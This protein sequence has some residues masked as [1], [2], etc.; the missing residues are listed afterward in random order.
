MRACAQ[1]DTAGLGVV[2]LD[3]LLDREWVGEE[4]ITTD[5]GQHH[6][7]RV[8]MACAWMS[9]LGGWAGSVSGLHEAGIAG[10][11]QRVG[12]GVCKTMSRNPPRTTSPCL[13]RSCAVPSSTWKRSVWY[14]GS[15]KAGMQRRAWR[16]VARYSPRRTLDLV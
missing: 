6:K 16:G 9:R 8:C 7:V 10:C 15:G 5:L 2:I 1:V 3:Y 14:R 11:C 12:V 4:Q 13:T